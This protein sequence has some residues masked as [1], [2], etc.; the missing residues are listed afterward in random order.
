MEV[1]AWCPGT[2][3]L[4]TGTVSAPGKHQGVGWG[5]TRMGVAHSGQGHGQPQP[6]WHRHKDKDS[7]G[8]PGTGTGK[9][10]DTQHKDSDGA[11]GGCGDTR[12]G[13]APAGIRAHG[14]GLCPTGPWRG[15]GWR[16]EPGAVLPAR[17]GPSW[18][19]ADP[20]RSLSGSWAGP[21]PAPPHGAAP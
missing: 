4:E 12:A 18:A 14:G 21:S 8:T 20:A 17:A 6:T 15:P 7:H 10:M 1:S 9:M 5:S 3:H 19:G 16:A 13:S 2:A 11:P